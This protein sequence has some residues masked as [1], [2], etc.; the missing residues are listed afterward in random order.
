M[1]P[2]FF[3]SQFFS[4]S[5]PG[6]KRR[7][8]SVK[9]GPERETGGQQACRASKN[10]R[11]R[12]KSGFF[13]RQWG[14]VGKS[15]STVTHPLLQRVREREGGGGGGTEWEVR[16]PKEPKWEWP[17]P[18]E[19]NDRGIRKARFPFNTLNYSGLQGTHLHCR[20]LCF[21]FL[22]SLPFFPSLW[23][24]QENG[25]ASGLGDRH[26]CGSVHRGKLRPCKTG[27]YLPFP[28]KAQVQRS[29]R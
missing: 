4:N 23:L 20:C 14:K 18:A 25:P 7:G 19:V 28:T 27:D 24:E 13:W 16:R 11:G 26:I 9:R 21:P 17:T 6:R 12:K 2:L 15:K 22:L 10:K 1:G 29:P 3:F 5:S 8:L